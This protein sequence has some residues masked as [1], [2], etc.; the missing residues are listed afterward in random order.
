MTNSATTRLNFLT[1]FDLLDDW[2]AIAV[3]HLSDVEQRVRVPV[4]RRPVVHKDPG[5]T[6]ATVHHDPII[7]SRVED[8]GGLHGLSDGEVPGGKNTG[9]L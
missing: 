5:T 3:L 1:G 2:F 8:I 4:V 9:T 7:Q 6:A